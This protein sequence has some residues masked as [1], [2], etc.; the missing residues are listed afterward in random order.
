[1]VC[2]DLHLLIHQNPNLC[3]VDQEMNIVKQT[4]WPHGPIFKL[5]WSSALHKFIV[6]D[7]NNVFLVDKNTLSTEIVCAIEKQEWLSCTCSDTFLFLSTNELAPSIIQFG[8]LPSMKLVKESKSPHTCAGNE[9]IHDIVCR[10]ETLA[11]IIMNTHDKSM[12]IELRLVD[13][14]D[15]I[16]SLRLDILY[17]SNIAFSCCAHTHN[18]WLIADYQ[19]GRL[20]HITKDGK[21]KKTIEY[22]PCPYRVC[23]FGLNT[24]AISRK[25]GI[26]FHKM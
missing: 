6:I 8:P 20:L 4:V 18:E 21:M 17:N 22:N 7:K 9:M 15:R 26:N 24:L 10:N 25:G 3:L 23:L 2:N 11:L 19:N 5:C 16:W 14:L 1:L 12:R 13:T